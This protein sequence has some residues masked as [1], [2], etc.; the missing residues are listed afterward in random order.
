LSGLDLTIHGNRSPEVRRKPN[1]HAIKFPRCDSDDGE[2]VSV[3][4]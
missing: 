1:Q 4:R 2:V 3:E